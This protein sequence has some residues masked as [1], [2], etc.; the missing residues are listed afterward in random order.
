MTKGILDLIEPEAVRCEA[1]RAMDDWGSPDLEER[2][3]SSVDGIETIES[4]L[5]HG[6]YP[7]GFIRFRYVPENP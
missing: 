4:R 2:V 6:A 5:P 7:S 3:I 1:G